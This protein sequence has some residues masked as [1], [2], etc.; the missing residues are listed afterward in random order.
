MLPQAFLL[1]F[2]DS[3]AL[4]CTILIFCVKRTIEVARFTVELLLSARSAP[5]LAQLGRATAATHDGN[6]AASI[7]SCLQAA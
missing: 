6:H 3:C 5:I 1:Q 7:R 4:L 2:F